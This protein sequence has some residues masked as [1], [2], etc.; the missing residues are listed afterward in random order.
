VIGLGQAWYKPAS[1]AQSIEAAGAL[2]VLAL[3]I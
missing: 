3:I 1:R 2:S